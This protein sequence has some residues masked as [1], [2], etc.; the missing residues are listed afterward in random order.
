MY[1]ME[2]FKTLILIPFS[3]KS[4]QGCDGMLKNIPGSAFSAVLVAPPL[5]I[6]LTDMLRGDRCNFSKL[7]IDLYDF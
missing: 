2:E 3:W 1:I 5:L 7:I 6:N 4:N